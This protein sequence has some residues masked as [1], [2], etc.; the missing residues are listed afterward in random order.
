L[1]PWDAIICTTVFKNLTG[2]DLRIAWCGWY[3]KNSCGEW[4]ELVSSPEDE[5]CFSGSSVGREFPRDGSFLFSQLLPTEEA[6][7]GAKIFCLAVGKGGRVFGLEQLVDPDTSISRWSRE[8]MDGGG[9]WGDERKWRDALDPQCL[10]TSVCRLSESEILK[11]DGAR[12][13]A[14][15]VSK[16]YGGEFLTAYSTVIKNTTERRVRVVWF[17]SYEMSETGWRGGNISGRTLGP[18][19]FVKWFGGDMSEGSGWIDAGGEARCD[20][21]WKIEKSGTGNELIWL[22]VAVDDN[23][24]ICCGRGDLASG[25]PILID[26]IR[27]KYP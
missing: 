8:G 26:R 20:F 4:E 1:E 19:D 9:S 27:W 13:I 17:Q 22:Y 14:G 23:G 18:L 7:W 16:D 3:L 15:Q 21:N 6:A 5:P 2:E 11:I 24:N 12:T 25:D 10:K